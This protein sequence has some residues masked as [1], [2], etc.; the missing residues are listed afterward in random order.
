MYT[1]QSQRRSTP[2]TFWF[3][4]PKPSLHAYHLIEVIDLNDDHGWVLQDLID[5]TVQHHLLE[6]Q[7]LVP[8]RT[9][10][11]ILHL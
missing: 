1:D 4:T 8:V 11:F 5:G 2:G 10:G 9:Q 3:S 6:E 7:S